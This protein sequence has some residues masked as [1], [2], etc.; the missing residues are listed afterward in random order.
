[1]VLNVC[2]KDKVGPMQAQGSQ[3]TAQALRETPEIHDG[4]LGLHFPVVLIS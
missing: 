4:G 2:R 1:M 3:D